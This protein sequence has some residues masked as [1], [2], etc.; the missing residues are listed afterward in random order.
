MQIYQK[1]FYKQKSTNLAA[2]VGSLFYSK[3]TCS[4]VRNICIYHPVFDRK[5]Q[6]SSALDTALVQIEIIFPDRKKK[7]IGTGIYIQKDQWDTKYHQVVGNELANKFNRIIQSTITNLQSAEL[8]AID[9]GEPWTPQRI[10]AILTGGSN[11]LSFVDFAVK[12]IEARQ[13]IKEVSRKN[14]MASFEALKASGIH[15][16]SD[17]T[18]NN[19]E[20][21][22]NDLHRSGKAQSTIHKIHKHIRQ[23]IIVAVKHGLFTSGKNPYQ[24]FKATLGRTGIR[25]RLDDA[26]MEVIENIKLEDSRMILTRDMFVFSMYTGLAYRDLTLLTRDNIRFVNGS[27]WIEGLRRKS[28]EYYSVPLLDPALRIIE[29]YKGDGKVIF[30]GPDLVEQNRR[31]KTLSLICEFN[32]QLTTHVARHTC[33]TFLLR[34]GISLKTVS[35]ILGHSNI[36]TT[37]IYAKLERERVREE[38]AGL[39]TKL[40]GGKGKL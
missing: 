17:I 32:K 26:E 31:L 24:H 8:D 22:D 4:T 38:F 25:P 29:K 19:I 36:S 1:E 13:D 21:F 18:L 28:G 12:H 40:S 11:K 33:A 14:Q 16:F 9:S 34:K 6:T 5:K 3:D 30:K 23:Y 39:Q 35:E 2:L 15:Y 20:K 37:E 10:D 7:Y 27:Y